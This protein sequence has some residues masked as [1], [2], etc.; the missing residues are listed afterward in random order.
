MS[1]DEVRFDLEVG[2]GGGAQILGDGEE[3][4]DVGAP[5]SRRVSAA[6]AA[7]GR[8]PDRVWIALLVCVA[9]VAVL[10]GTAGRDSHRASS[11]AIGTSASATTAPAGPQAAPDPAGDALNRVLYL[12][13]SAG[14]LQDTNR[15]TATMPACTA[16]PIGEDPARSVASALGK[17]LPGFTSVDSSVTTL[18]DSFCALNVR[19]RNSL[20]ATVIV[21]IVA[22][23]HGMGPS[24]DVERSNDR[25]TVGD[26]RVFRGGWQVDVGWVAQAGAPVSLTGVEAVAHDRELRW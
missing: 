23:P 7:F 14:S 8:V 4:L 1:D 25:R 11:A 19:A 6:L 5:D 16:T 15:S 24:F 22:P 3:L 21:T 2:R 13:E 17:H 26:V 20:G 9:L 12:A 10:V 18:L